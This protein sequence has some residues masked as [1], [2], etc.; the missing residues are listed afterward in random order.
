[1]LTLDRA[2]REYDAA[3]IVIPGNRIEALGPG[4]PPASRVDDV[5]VIEGGGLLAMPGLI[6]GH[7]HSPGNLMKGALANTPLELFMLYEVPPLMDK[8]V[9]P[10]FA[11][12]RTMLGI[13][14]CSSR[15]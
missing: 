1:M 6:N 7:L 8:T 3:D 4:L 9:S 12:V 15:A 2:D 13:S 5:R 11:Y 14:R 10:R